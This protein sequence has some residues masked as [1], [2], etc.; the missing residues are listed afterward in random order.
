MNPNLVERLENLLAELTEA[1][2][3]V[4]QSREDCGD[5]DGNLQNASTAI[6]NAGGIAGEILTMIDGR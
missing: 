5:S 3:S 6:E 1:Q 4:T 2:D